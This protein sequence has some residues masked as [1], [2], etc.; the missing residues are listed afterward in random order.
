[1]SGQMSLL[2]R[3]GITERV[4]VIPERLYR[5]A[6][7]DFVGVRRLARRSVAQAGAVA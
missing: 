2:E 6:R 7:L 5:L 3:E 4:R 1:M